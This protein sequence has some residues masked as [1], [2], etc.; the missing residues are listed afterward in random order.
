MDVT[1][2]VG[3]VKRVFGVRI[4]ISVPMGMVASLQRH[5][6]VSLVPALGVCASLTLIAVRRSGI[7]DAPTNATPIA[8][9]AC[10]ALK[11]AEIRSADLMDADGS[12]AHALKGRY[13]RMDIVLM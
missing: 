11:H 8:V 4:F 2:A 5:L 9:D 6:V 1:G 12:V 13:V 10:L 3:S 7:K